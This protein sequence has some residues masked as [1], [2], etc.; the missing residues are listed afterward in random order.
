MIRVVVALLYLIAAAVAFPQVPRGEITVRVVDTKGN[1]V[2]AAIVRM[3]APPGRTL[4]YAVPECTT[5]ATGTCSRDDLLIDTYYVS[6]MKPSE[7]Y[8]N[9]SFSFYGHNR[10]P[11]VV[12]LTPNRP[13]ASV[14]FI[15]GPKCGVVTITAV[16]KGF[17]VPIANPTIILSRPSNPEDQLVIGKSADSQVLIPPDEDVL[18]EASAKGYKRWHMETQPEATHANALHLHSGESRQFTIRLEPG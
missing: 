9:L 17:G 7:G 6:A 12:D 18:V 14:P 2:S 1:P 13:K 15:V 10:K 4:L 5:D 16:D 8:P 3:H 11:V